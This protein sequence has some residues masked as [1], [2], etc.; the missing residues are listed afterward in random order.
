[1][2]LD[3]LETVLLAV[4]LSMDAFAVAMCKGLASA[5]APM[6]DCLRCGCWFGGF[7]ALMPVLGF[8]LGGIFAGAIEVVDH[9]VILTL[10][11]L[12]GFNMIREANGEE[13]CTGGFS[14]KEMIF[15]ALA[16]SIDALAVGISLAMTG[17]VRIFPTAALIGVTTCGLSAFGVRL[18]SRFGSRYGA[19]AQIAGGVILIFLG[20]KIFLEHVTA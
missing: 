8:F 7:Q 19:R 5:G 2:A 4:G 11:T 16:T 20:V 12:I 9:W 6:G 13:D 1:M 3:L 10:L 14:P 17:G 15:P 18:G